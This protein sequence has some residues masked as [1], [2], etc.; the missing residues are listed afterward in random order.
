[1]SFF[2]VTAYFKYYVTDEKS[3]TTFTTHVYKQC[4]Q[5]H[6]TLRGITLHLFFFTP[7]VNITNMIINIIKPTIENEVLQVCI[8]NCAAHFVKSRETNE[9]D[10]GS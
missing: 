9:A 10:A 3:P 7:Y 4:L 2:N 5:I 1:M 8:W 6:Y